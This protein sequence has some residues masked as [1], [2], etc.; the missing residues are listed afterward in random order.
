MKKA[1]TLI[2]ILVV[3]SVIALLLAILMPALA[4]ARAQTRS[5]VCKMH[6][7]QLLLANISYASENDGFFAAAA[8]DMLDGPGLH[9]WHGI[10]DNLN[11]PF[12]PQRGPLASYLSD[13][14]VKECP[15]KVNFIKNA[16]WNTNFEQGCGGYGYNM[17]YIGSRLWQTGLKSEQDWINAY[18]KTTKIQEIKIPAMTLFFSDTAISNDANSL[19]E[20]SFAEPPFAVQNGFPVTSFYMSPS[21][22]F[23]HRDKANTGW[24]DG[25]VSNCEIAPFDNTNVYKVKSADLNLGWFDPID[26]SQFDLK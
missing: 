18:A 25:H 15:A 14:R 7:R 2:E 21:I 23:R 17:T 1:F 13:S 3:I 19:I 11:E 4:A 22:H 16:D 20:Y 10:R 6:L 5:L 12:D 26:N 8:S 24:G 9:R